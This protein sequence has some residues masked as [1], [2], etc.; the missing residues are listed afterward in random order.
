M[1]QRP[2]WGSWCVVPELWSHLVCISLFLSPPSPS[3]LSSSRGRLA[4]QCAPGSC[5]PPST[6]LSQENQGGRRSRGPGRGL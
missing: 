2:W 6:S 1:V 5:P 3:P 4:C